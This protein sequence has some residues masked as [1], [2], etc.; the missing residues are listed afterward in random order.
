MSDVYI[1]NYVIVYKKLRSFY[2]LC[3]CVAG[4]VFTMGMILAV[5]R[6]KCSKPEETVLSDEQL[7]VYEV[8]VLPNILS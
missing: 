7:S 3:E 4:G 2:L 5:F 1:I 8:M 6:R